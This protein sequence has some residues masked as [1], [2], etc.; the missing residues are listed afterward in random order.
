MTTAPDKDIES[1]ILRYELQLAR[2]ENQERC[3]TDFLSYVKHCWPE[4]IPGRH[5][6][7][8]AEKFEQVAQGKLKRLI[9]CLAPRHT[10]SEFGS[11]LLP[12]WMM[13]RKPNMQII[14]A[15]HTAELAMGFGR[16]VKNL[17]DSDTYRDIFSGFSLAADSKAKGRWDTDKGGRYYALGV[18]GA[19][20]GRGADLCLPPQTLVE[21]NGVRMP[22]GNVKEGDQI[23]THFGRQKVT[24]KKLTTHEASVILN[25]D[26]ESSTNH[27]FCVKKQNRR[28]NDWVQAQ[29]VQV[30]DRLQT[31]TI[32]RRL[33]T[34]ANFLLKTLSEKPGE[35]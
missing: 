22:I 12:S 32:W 6:K 3:Q 15:T 25:G 34:G 2:L 17:I 29:D 7:I 11:Y 19:M 31:T 28:G 24:R 35:A 23:T 10:K 13:G 14:Q 4:F 9:V 26:L 27:R 30:G 1:Q 16:R 21:I 8:M 5:H 33:W 18:G 20:A